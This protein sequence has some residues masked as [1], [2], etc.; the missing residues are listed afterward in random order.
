MVVVA[1][2]DAEDASAVAAGEELDS[3]EAEVPLAPEPDPDL[4]EV[5]GHRLILGVDLL[6]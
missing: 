3:E 4:R 6:G 2:P 1:V 5:S